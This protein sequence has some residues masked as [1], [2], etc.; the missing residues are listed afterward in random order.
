MTL[1]RLEGPFPGAANDIGSGGQGVGG[2]PEV[3]VIGTN[4]RLGGY[5]IYRWNGN[6]QGNAWD[7]QPGGATRIDLDDNGIPWV[8]NAQN[9]I[10]MWD[11]SAFKP[12]PGGAKDIGAGGGQVWVIGT[13]PRPGG[14][15]IYRW[16]AGFEGNVWDGPMGGGAAGY[17]IA[18]DP[19]GNAWVT[20][21][22]NNIFV[23]DGS[24]FKP[25]LGLAS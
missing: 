23:W 17:R 11:G 19:A 14:F 5:G 25:P 12:L 16:H 20:N 24:V 21:E 8:V 15:G 2:L 18:V 10:F 3:W 7:P 6:V 9:N 13:D 22:Q 1:V 4:P